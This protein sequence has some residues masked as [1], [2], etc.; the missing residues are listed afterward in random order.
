MP[1][2]PIPEHL[3]HRPED[4]ERDAERFDHLCELTEEVSFPIV[5]EALIRETATTGAEVLTSEAK[6]A[7]RMLAEDAGN[8]LNIGEHEVLEA[9]Q[10]SFREQLTPIG[11]QE[12]VADQEY[13]QH[14]R[15][16]S[17]V[18][19]SI[20]LESLRST[21][22]KNSILML[23]DYLF[24]Q[25]SPNGLMRFIEWFGGGKPKLPERFTDAISSF[26]VNGSDVAQIM[27]TLRVKLFT[28][29]LLVD[30]PFDLVMI[31][32]PQSAVLAMPRSLYDRVVE[33][34]GKHFRSQQRESLLDHESTQ[35]VIMKPTAPFFTTVPARRAV[36]R[37]TEPL[38]PRRYACVAKVASRDFET[39][40]L[41]SHVMQAFS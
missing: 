14:A 18:L 7:L 5:K 23:S 32:A 39:E 41:Q 6:N 15:D 16:L 13:R 30:L 27:S 9:V 33:A 37:L 17:Q 2:T 36:D 3:I 28:E 4:V 40:T 1:R 24:P 22:V 21:N 26:A 12:S 8:L 31:S 19:V 29:P 35:P 34:I 20:W 10:K 11:D 25:D 38:S